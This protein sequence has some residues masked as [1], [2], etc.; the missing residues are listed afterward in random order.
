MSDNLL[1]VTNDNFI[2]EVLNSDLPVV[3]D[4]WAE[5]CGPCRM[6]IPVLKDVAALYVDK[7]K[8]VKINVDE[9]SDLAHQYGVRSIPTLVF[10]KD[11]KAIFTQTGALGR[12]QLISLLKEHFALHDE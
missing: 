12:P 9:A 10:L 8:F 11:G 1:H 4:F 6:L 2:T 7:V 3:I 5:W